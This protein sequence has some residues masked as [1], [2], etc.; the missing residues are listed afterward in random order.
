VALAVVGIFG[1]A[2]GAVLLATARLGRAPSARGERAGQALRRE[3]IDLVRAR[4]ELVVHGRM[5]DQRARVRAEDQA[6]RAAAVT[7]DRVDR[8]AGLALSL[9]VAAAM[10]AAMAIGGGLVAAGHLA[11][12]MAVL[13][14]FVALALAE[15]TPALQRGMAEL[16]RM[17]DAAGRVME[18]A[19]AAP[20]G[21]AAAALPVGGGLEVSEL[22]YRRPGAERPI[23]A[24]LS[25]H[26]T[27]R[28]V[29]SLAGPSG[30]GKSTLLWVLAGLLPAEAG[31]VRLAGAR[32]DALGEADLRARLVLLP[33]RTALVAGTVLE[34]LALARDGITEE[35]AWAALAAAGLDGVVRAKGGLGANLGESGAGLSGGEQRRLALAR[36]LLRRPRVLL[37]DEPTE[38]LDGPTAARVLQG[39]RD[40]LPD[41]AILTASH[42]QAELDWADRVVRLV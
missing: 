42:R 21:A 39:I 34:N 35:E 41:A 11:G 29:V 28:E 36:V 5:E 27:P 3:V 24:G 32:L 25:L 12:P 18:R 16:G 19:G 38:G 26:V 6:A 1:L 9:V 17:Q 15:L 13:A 2:G 31:A 30:T 37:L 8:G 40:F 7:L 23:F 33:Q 4:V 20:G 14:V 10:A 22:T